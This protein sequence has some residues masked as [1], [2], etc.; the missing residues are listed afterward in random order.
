[1]Y[2]D[3]S[4]IHFSRKHISDI[5]TKV[6]ED[7]NRIELCCKDNNMFINCNKT[8]YMTIGTK[9]KL[10]CQNE[11]LTLTI[12]SEQLQHSACEKLLGI[13]IFSNPNWKN[14]IDQKDLRKKLKYKVK[15]RKCGKENSCFRFR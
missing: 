2:A 10:S 7:L 4:T 6:H 5:Q 3:D 13:N 15:S 8:K 11:E 14:Q 1:M 9:Q 12:N